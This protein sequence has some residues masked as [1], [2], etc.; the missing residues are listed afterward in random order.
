MRTPVRHLSF[1]MCAALVL[2]IIPAAATTAQEPIPTKPLSLSTEGYICDWLICGPFPDPGKWPN[3]ANWDTDLL[4]HDGGEAK[5]RPTE[6]MS[7][8]AKL[9]QLGGK[10]LT[11]T[12]Q[13]LMIDPDLKD[14]NFLIDLNALFKATPFGGAEPDRL[15]AYAFCYL[16]APA[17]MEAKL[18]VGSDDGFKA[19]LNGKQ[20]AAVCVKRSP[21][22]D[23][24]VI[25][26]KLEKGLNPL[27]LKV[28]DD[29]GGY[30]FMVRLTA[31]NDQPLRAVK[32]WLSVPEK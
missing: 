27:L 26:I 17:D 32:V 5:I 29:V 2:A 3:L 28:E 6:K 4:A 21:A 11:L 20:V 7:Y 23:Q 14:Y 19:W 31:T 10:E 25:S 9:L 30:A 1:H 12:W 15:I 13:P 18:R 8:K 22:P 24:N 16:A